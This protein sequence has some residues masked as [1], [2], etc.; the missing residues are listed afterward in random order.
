MAQQTINL[1]TSANDGTGD[2]LRSAMDKT[3][4]NFTELYGANSVSSNIALS[5]NTVSTYAT[6][7]DIILGPNG[8]GQIRIASN[9]IPDVN[10]TRYIGN[11]NVRPLAIY[12]GTGGINV[13]NNSTI[14]TNGQ[15][16]INGNADVVGLLDCDSFNTSGNAEVVGN[17][18]CGNLSTPGAMS[19]G[20]NF[21]TLAGNITAVGGSVTGSVSMIM[22]TYA[23]NTARD[24]A[25]TSPSAGMTIFKTDIAKLQFYDGA[26]WRTI[27]ST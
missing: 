21:G 18:S 12:V 19:V 4:D 14:E 17:I 1:G 2:N 3:N 13:S 9:I 20:T 15:I 25:I 23:N 5:G 7:Q 27:T 11:A 6:N 8:T 26:Q 24:S 10:N 16:Y 22:P